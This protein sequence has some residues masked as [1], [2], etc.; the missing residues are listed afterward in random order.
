[1]AL[2]QGDP[3]MSSRPLTVLL[4][5]DGTLLD[6]NEAHA[7][8]WLQTLRCNGYAVAYDKV[9]PLIGKSGNGF[10]PELLGHL[11]DPRS[12]DRMAE[13]RWALFMR[14]HLPCLCPTPGAH[15]LL[16]RLRSDGLRLVAAT[17]APGE[18]L[19]ALLRQA[20]VDD[21]I[22]DAMVVGAEDCTGAKQGHEVLPTLL[23]N[24]AASAGEAILIGDTPYDI[25][26]ARAVGIDTIALRCGGWWNDAA[27]SAAVAIYDDPSDL[28]RRL[29]HSPL[30]PHLATAVPSRP[31]PNG[32]QIDETAVDAH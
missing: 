21:L 24:A 29:A 30:A 8:S 1:M 32:A 23:E 19:Q 14:S 4:D 6:S 22:G 18:A 11:P 16:K 20:G 17:S 10:L 13:E 3:S 26:S 9:R 2:S 31:E 28:L 25:Q 15:A 5:I 12:I 7:C 27:L